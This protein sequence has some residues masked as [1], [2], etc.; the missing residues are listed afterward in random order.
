M[1]GISVFPW[2]TEWDPK[3]ALLVSITWVVGSRLR[4]GIPLWVWPKTPVLNFITWASG[5]RFRRGIPLWICVIK[6]SNN[7][8]LNFYFTRGSQFLHG[9]HNFS[10]FS[11]S[12]FPYFVIL[13]H[14]HVR[15]FRISM[16]FRMWP[17]NCT[18]R[19]HNLG[20][21]IPI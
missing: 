18:S 2:L 12:Q 6:F 20:N 10:P 7:L 16:A 19:F 14:F 21:W 9:G 17:K 5:S 11:C 13:A 4:R 15:N 1:F 3:T 8:D